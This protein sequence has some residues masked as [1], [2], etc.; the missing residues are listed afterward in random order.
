MMTSLSSLRRLAR[1]LV[2]DSFAVNFAPLHHRFNRRLEKF[3][4]D[5]R[6]HERAQNHDGDENR[7]LRLVND[8]VLQT[9]QRRD[10]AEGQSGGHEQR[11]VIRSEEHT[12]ELQSPM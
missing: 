5:E 4:R 11:G 1:L 8:F 10:R 2:V 6:W 12:S 7:V 3:L 9:E